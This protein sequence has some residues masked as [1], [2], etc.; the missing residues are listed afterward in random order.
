MSDIKTMFKDMC[1][2]YSAETVLNQIKSC[3]V[4]S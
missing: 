1:D 3:T 2:Q 4:I